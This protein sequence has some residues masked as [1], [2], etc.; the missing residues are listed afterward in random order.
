LGLVLA[1]DIADLR[2]KPPDDD[3]GDVEIEI[4]EADCDED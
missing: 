1:E 3:S 4:R 2:A